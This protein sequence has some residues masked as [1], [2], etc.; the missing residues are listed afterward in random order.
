MESAT[1]NSARS[2]SA[3][4]CSPLAIDRTMLAKVLNSICFGLSSGCASKKGMTRRSKSS[5]RRTTNT[6][7]V[8]ELPRWFSCTRPH[9]R[10]PLRRSSTTRRSTL[11]DLKLRHDLDSQLRAR[12]PLDGYM[13][14][15]FSIDETS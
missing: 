2:P 6:K 3:R 15:A 13:K 8:S 14:A 9:A 10:R 11:T 7:E 5:R 12:A 1:S 4:R